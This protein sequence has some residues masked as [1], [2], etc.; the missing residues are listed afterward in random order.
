M[1]G[2]KRVGYGLLDWPDHTNSKIWLQNLFLKAIERLEPQKE[3][4]P[5]NALALSPLQLYTDFI[6]EQDRQTV[7][8]R[9]TVR[10]RWDSGL[11]FFNLL[12]EDDP[13]R[14]SIQQWGEAYHLSSAWC[15][16][17][18]LRTLQH[19]H[20]FKEA[21]G[22]GFESIP[23]HAH[24]DYL[25]FGSQ[26]MAND[27]ARMPQDSLNDEQKELAGSFK[28][29]R[30]VESFNEQ[31]RAFLSRY[32]FDPHSIS[33]GFFWEQIEG[34]IEAGLFSPGLPILGILRKSELND[35]RDTI[36]ERAKELWKRLKQ[37][38]EENNSVKPMEVGA[39]EINRHVE[40]AVRYQIFGEDYSL[41]DSRKC[42]HPGDKHRAGV[43]V[44]KA[45][46]KILGLIDLEPRR[47]AK[48]RR[49]NR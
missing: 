15:Y 3:K 29:R 44:R 40:W 26:L 18:A 31:Q 47:T 22:K 27:L 28:K 12:D 20:L 23:F 16:D 37:V 21:A 4:K 49:R 46:I 36:R 45:V 43:R 41:I 39:S 6:E 1:R 11:S 30:F 2:R 5:L 14:I 7:S 32:P 24:P 25:G 48:G 17:V 35:L 33:Y 13:L 8:R 42:E 38:A 19:W 34:L 9:Q 10:D